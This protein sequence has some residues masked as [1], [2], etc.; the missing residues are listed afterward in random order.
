M[1]TRR[2]LRRLNSAIVRLENSLSRYAAI[3]GAD[4]F[5]AGDLAEDISTA[6]A[7]FTNRSVS[8]S[9]VNSVLEAC[10]RILSEVSGSPAAGPVI[11]AV[12]DLQRI[13]RELDS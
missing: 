13:L 2:E 5:W 10:A 7:V 6:A 8:T 3:G 4:K 12:H 11:E 1:A 9:A